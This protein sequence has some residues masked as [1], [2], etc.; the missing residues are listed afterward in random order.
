MKIKPPVWNKGGCVAT[1]HIQIPGGWLGYRVEFNRYVVTGVFNH[2]HKDDKWFKSIQETRT[3]IEELYY[4]Q[5]NKLLERWL[6]W[7]PGE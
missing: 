5:V 2:E 4:K 1:E 6:E 3:Y 7:Q